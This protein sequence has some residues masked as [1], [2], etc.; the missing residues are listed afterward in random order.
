ML[1]PLIT[2][3]HAQ[4]SPDMGVHVNV[5]TSNEADDEER[6]KLKSVI[7]WPT[8][9][10]DAI[11]AG[12]V[13]LFKWVDSYAQRSKRSDKAGQHSKLLDQSFLASEIYEVKDVDKFSNTMY[14][15]KYQTI[16]HFKWIYIWI[17]TNAF[18]YKLKFNFQE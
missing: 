9:E 14:E 18:D 12:V 17:F 13:H 1:G 4:F 16:W 15:R 11:R 6:S 7:K 3:H 10:I 2:S 5:T 8:K